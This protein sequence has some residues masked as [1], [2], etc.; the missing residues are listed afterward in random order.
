M[1]CYTIVKMWCIFQDNRPFV[2]GKLDM[3]K[4]FNTQENRILY[5]KNYTW[6]KN[7]TFLNKAITHAKKHKYGIKL[8][9]EEFDY[10]RA[11]NRT[12]SQ[13]M[14]I[15]KQHVLDTRCKTFEEINILLQ[16]P[17][18]RIFKKRIS[19]I[20]IFYIDFVNS[21]KRAGYED[22]TMMFC[23]FMNNMNEQAR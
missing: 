10:N 7:V 2:I 23:D 4:H 9:L 5:S 11:I 3:V 20:P 1:N 18:F 12:Q 16:T 8:V 13:Y 21:N 17:F 19:C 14:Q 6:E 15:Q 22:V